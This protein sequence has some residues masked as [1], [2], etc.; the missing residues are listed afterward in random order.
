MKKT[1]YLF[2]HGAVE[3][4]YDGRCRGSTDCELSEQGMLMAQANAEFLIR[5]KIDAIVTTG[6][7]RTDYMGKLVVEA[8]DIPNITY[9]E[10]AEMRLGKWEGQRWDAI[11]KETPELYAAFS[12]DPLSVH[13]PSAEDPEDYRKRVIDGWQRI[14]EYPASSIGVNSHRITNAIILAHIRQ[15]TA[16]LEQEAGC[17]NEIEVTDDGA[18]IVRENVILFEDG[19]REKPHK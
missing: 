5:Q 17:M 19:L 15:T 11:C 1:I 13:V 6:M 18:R 2:R 9:P 10:L 4:A 3:E 16:K 12:R 7:K 14:T 8:L